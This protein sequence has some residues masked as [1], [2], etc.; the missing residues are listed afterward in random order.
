M[1]LT[2][3][4]NVMY[5][6]TEYQ[7]IDL[8]NNKIILSI[9][10]DLDIGKMTDL[11][12]DFSKDNIIIYANNIILSKQL[13]AASVRVFANKIITIS[14][15]TKEHINNKKNM[16]LLVDEDIKLPTNPILELFDYSNEKY[17]S[18]KATSCKDGLL[19]F[20]E[21]CNSGL[22]NINLEH[23][24]FAHPTQ[25]S[26]LLQKAQLLYREA[27]PVENKAAL[28]QAIVFLSYL[29]DLTKIFADLQDTAPLVKLYNDNHSQIIT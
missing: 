12:E 21:Q 9:K 28:D 14:K 27:D 15:T 23:F 4:D 25:C 13:K 6:E 7:T 24:M 8:G 18:I 16:V 17:F 1:R 11:G 20:A 10:D 29:R 2:D 3:Y 5:Q 26:M 22:V 19:S